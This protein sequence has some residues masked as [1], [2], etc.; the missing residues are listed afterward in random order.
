MLFNCAFCNI[1]SLRQDFMYNLKVFRKVFIGRK[2]KNMHKNYQKKK[3]TL[4]KN[5]FQ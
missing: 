3:K 5:S 1:T 2:R 4:T